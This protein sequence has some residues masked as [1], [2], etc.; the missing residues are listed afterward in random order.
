MIP[1]GKRR[2]VSIPAGEPAATLTAWDRAWAA[3]D[4]GPPDTGDDLT[5]EAWA[6]L[7]RIW[8]CAPT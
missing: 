7:W 2:V 5:G 8:T 6:V 3:L 4:A 1:K